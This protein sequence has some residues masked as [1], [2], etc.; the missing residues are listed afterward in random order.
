[1]Y[2]LENESKKLRAPTDRK[3]IRRNLYNGEIYLDKEIKIQSIGFCHTD[4]TFFIT[5]GMKES[6]DSLR[7][8]KTIKITMKITTKISISHHVL[9]VIIA[10]GRQVLNPPKLL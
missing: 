7:F 10:A 5:L 6:P 4:Q 1:M 2:L 8:V 9:K 3:A